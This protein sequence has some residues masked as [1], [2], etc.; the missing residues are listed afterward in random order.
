MGGAGRL[1]VSAAFNASFPPEAGSAEASRIAAAAA[2]A[3][4]AAVAAA[5]IAAAAAL[6][7]ANQGS[8][9]VPSSMQRNKA[10]ILALHGGVVMDTFVAQVRLQSTSCLHVVSSLEC[11]VLHKGCTSTTHGGS[12]GIDIN[13]RLDTRLIQSGMQATH[14]H[15]LNFCAEGQCISF[16]Q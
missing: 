6:R 5:S 10:V 15:P 14:N 7:L 11:G 1:D 9:A 8:A 2:A 4:A 13:C 16:P 3:S 12:M